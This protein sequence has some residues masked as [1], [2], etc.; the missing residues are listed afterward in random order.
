MGEVEQERKRFR[1]TILEIA[2]SMWYQK[3]LHKG[4]KEAELL[5][6]R[7]GKDISTVEERRS[8]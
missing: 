3:E 4:K 5:V 1:E 7:R 8:L 2:R 6:E